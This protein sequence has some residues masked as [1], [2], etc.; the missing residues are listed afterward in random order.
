MCDEPK[1]KSVK[2]RISKT[3]KEKSRPNLAKMDDLEFGPNDQG[4]LQDGCRKCGVMYASATELKLHF[5]AVHQ[6]QTFECFVCNKLFLQKFFFLAHIDK[7][8]EELGKNYSCQYCDKVSETIGLLLVTCL[9]FLFFN[10][11]TLPE[12]L[13]TST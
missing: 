4:E 9:K 1:Q 5:A 3:L 12:R 8:H 10:R 7:Y 6:R 2:N 11:C 13:S